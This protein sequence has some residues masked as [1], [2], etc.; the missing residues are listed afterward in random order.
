M[1]KQT[2]YTA[3]LLPN[4]LL[5]IW[6]YLCKWQLIYRKDENGKWQPHNGNATIPANRRVLDM[7][8]DKKF[9]PISL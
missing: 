3:E 8:N 6:D 4:G 9:S 1:N 2:R 7:L 5:A